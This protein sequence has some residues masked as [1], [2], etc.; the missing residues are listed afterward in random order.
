MSANTELE[1][2]LRFYLPCEFLLARCCARKGEKEL[3]SFCTLLPTKERCVTT[4]K[5]VVQQINNS[6][7]NFISF[8]MQYI[9]LLLYLPSTEFD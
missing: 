2:E 1:R 9:F 3:K 8:I 4:L 5:T 6:F 7:I